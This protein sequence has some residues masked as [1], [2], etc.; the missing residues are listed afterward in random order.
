[1]IITK[2]LLQPGTSLLHHPSVTPSILSL[3]S[4]RT[5]VRQ[6]S[7]VLEQ[8][9]DLLKRL[10]RRLREQEENVDEHGYTE[11]AKDNVHLPADIDERRRDEVAE[12]KVEGPV[13]GRGERNGLASDAVGVQLGRVGP[14]DGTPGWCV[15]GDEE[16]GAGDDGAGGGA[17]DLGGGFRDVVDAVGAGIGAVGGEDAGV[18]EEPGCHQSGA[19]EEG[20]TT[21]PA[22]HEEEGGD[23]HQYVDDVLDGGGDQVGVLCQT[24]H[25]E[26]VSDCSN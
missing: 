11:D 16:V 9:R 8:T 25:G 26:Y 23:G 21:A 4:R 18:G 15:G 2:R 17:G 22:V 13:A 20:W 7:R 12:G 24:S 1:M 6:P 10:A 14:G 19:D 5:N 3:P